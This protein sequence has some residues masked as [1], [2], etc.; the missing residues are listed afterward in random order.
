ML[1][2]RPKAE[3]MAPMPCIPPRGPSCSAALVGFLVGQ[4]PANGTG[5]RFIKIG[6]A[7]VR[8]LGPARVLLSRQRTS[9]ASAD[10]YGRS[11]SRNIEDKQRCLSRAY[12]LFATV[13]IFAS[14]AGHPP[15]HSGQ[16]CYSVTFTPAAPCCRS[17]DAWRKAMR[18][19]RSHARLGSWLAL[20]ALALQLALSFGHIHL[21]DVLG[22][23]DASSGPSSRRSRRS[24]DAQEPA[25]PPADRA[26][27]RA[28]RRIL[29]DLRH[30]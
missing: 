16:D 7:V 18:W 17:R 8:D 21:K 10:R 29:R 3:V 2:S 1:T 6:R 20:S 27:P 5:P 24:S 28:R 13:A 19:F 11:T 12:D 22:Q 23:A 26:S 30:Q 25:A 15:V 9:T 4:V 14:S